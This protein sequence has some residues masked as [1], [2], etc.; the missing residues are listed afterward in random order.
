MS[1]GGALSEEGPPEPGG[2][3][4]GA[5]QGVGRDIGVVGDGCGGEGRV[6]CVGVGWEWWVGGWGAGAVCGAAG[7]GVVW[8]GCAS[9]CLTV[10]LS[11][12][13]VFV[14]WVHDDN[15]MMM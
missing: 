6:C 7:G 3:G 5:E 1:E 15:N 14:V 8:L 12:L 9:S 10:V 2:E 13:C 11:F 4:V